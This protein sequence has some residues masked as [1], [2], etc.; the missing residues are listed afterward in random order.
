MFVQWAN[1]L[2][3]LLI[4]Y[5]VVCDLKEDHNAKVI[6]NRFKNIEAEKISYYYL[7]E[8]YVQP[9]IAKCAQKGFK[10][11]ELG[12]IIPMA[13]ETNFTQRHALL[14]DLKT[15]GVKEFDDYEIPV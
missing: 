1:D 8:K 2:I 11:N 9:L 6:S 5:V 15:W 10:Y 13:F 14:E 3:I 12:E 4:D 7:E